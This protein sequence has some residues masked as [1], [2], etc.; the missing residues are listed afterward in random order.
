MSPVDLKYRNHLTV[1]WRK[2]TN[3]QTA[4]EAPIKWN[5][6]QLP[7]PPST[8]GTSWRPPLSFFP[9]LP[10]LR[11]GRKSRKNRPPQRLSIRNPADVDGF[12]RLLLTRPFIAAPLQLNFPFD[13]H[14]IFAMQIYLVYAN[15]LLLPSD[16][17]AV[18]DETLPLGDDEDVTD[19]ASPVNQ[20]TC[21]H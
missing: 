8:C 11:K 21:L 14:S 6:P 16:W 17:L 20:S 1:K 18:E 3:V 10:T 12:D 5:Y 13:A 7:P 19:A 9:A 15:E 2:W 4:E